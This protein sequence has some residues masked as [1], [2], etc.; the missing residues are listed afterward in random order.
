[1][2]APSNA[3]TA[4][5]GVCRSID[6]V[7]R[8]PRNPLEHLA[9]W[10]NLRVEEWVLAPWLWRPRHLAGMTA[11]LPRSRPRKSEPRVPLPLNN[12]ENTAKEG[13]ARNSVAPH[14]LPLPPG[15]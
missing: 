13:R 8:N 5:T 10:G 11:D 2:I 7:R 4:A 6:P 1:M 15:S 9:F 14:L 12:M 3:A